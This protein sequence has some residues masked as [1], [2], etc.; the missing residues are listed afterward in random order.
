MC[1]NWEIASVQCFLLSIPLMMLVY[2]YLNP[3]GV[4]TLN[5]SLDKAIPVVKWM[6][7]PYVT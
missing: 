3:R 7:V 5:T 2:P 1:N 6:V 4:H